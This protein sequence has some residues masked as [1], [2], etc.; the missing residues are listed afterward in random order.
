MQPL[1][2]KRMSTHNVLRRIAKIRDELGDIAT[3]LPKAVISRQECFD[4]LGQ[5]GAL[6]G[7]TADCIAAAAFNKLMKKAGPRF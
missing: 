7:K 2:R 3:R 1:N 6:L 4:N 5:A